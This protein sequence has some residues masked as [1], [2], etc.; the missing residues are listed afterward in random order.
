VVCYSSRVDG[1]LAR[2]EDPAPVE[3]PPCLRCL[4]GSERCSP[5]LRDR[6]EALCWAELE[7]FDA[8]YDRLVAALERAELWTQSIVFVLSDHGEGLDVEHGRIHH[9]GRLHAVAVIEGPYW[10]IRELGNEELY[11]MR[12]DHLQRQNL[13]PE[14]ES[15]ES[16][17]QLVAR[18]SIRETAPNPIDPYEELARQLRSLGDAE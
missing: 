14:E 12:S 7:H 15:L 3:D 13:A 4:R 18:R 5:L 16:Y 9:G 17:R 11:D 1:A 2:L 10:Y 8:G 6:P